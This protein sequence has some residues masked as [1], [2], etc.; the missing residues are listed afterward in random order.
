MTRH[1]DMQ[2]QPCTN[3]SNDLWGQKI[4]IDGNEENVKY[5]MNHCDMQIQTCTNENKRKRIPKGKS[6]MEN[7]EKLTTQGTQDE[8][9]QNKNTTQHVLDTTIRKSNVTK[10]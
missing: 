9:K 3:E 6:K 5:C 2:T 8:E 7:P 10:T 1:C 4:N